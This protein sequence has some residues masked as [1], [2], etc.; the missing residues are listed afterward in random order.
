MKATELKGT[1]ITEWAYCWHQ[2]AARAAVT[3]LTAL[4]NN[5]RKSESLNPTETV[6][7]FAQ[8]G[9]KS[10]PFPMGNERSCAD[11]LWGIPWH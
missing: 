10:I 6:K 11:A 4:V 2:S 5:L 7:L 1:C 3:M 8:V 9:R